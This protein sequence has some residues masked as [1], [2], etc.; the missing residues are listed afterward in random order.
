MGP[1]VQALRTD[2]ASDPAADALGR[3]IV[4]VLA[5][6]ASGVEAAR[7]DPV[8]GELMAPVHSAPGQAHGYEAS[9]VT[10]EGQGAGGLEVR[11][12]LDLAGLGFGDVS[13][14]EPGRSQDRVRPQG[15]PGKQ[16]SQDISGRISFAI[17]LHAARQLRPGRASE[18]EAHG[19]A[20]VHR[21]FGQME[22]P[23]S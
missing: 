11:F 14:S 16:A 21:G 18:W 15:K 9:S 5:G 20:H 6:V 2:R 12:D 8:A 1:S 22:E 19:G 3:L 10:F 4:R 13:L 23:R 7:R 17:P